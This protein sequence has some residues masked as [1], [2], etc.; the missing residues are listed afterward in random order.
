MQMLEQFDAASPSECYERRESVVPQQ[1]LALSN[2]VLALSQARLLAR[3]LSAAADG[4][5]AIGFITAAFEQVLGRAPTTEER[6]RCERFLA[7]QTTLLREPA[8]LTAFPAGP[9]GVVPPAAD[10]AQRAR[11][12]LVHVLFNHNDFITIR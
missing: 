6:T 11:E 9:N 5:T 8:K 1:A 4:A 10:A 7:E 12:N 2:S 3:N